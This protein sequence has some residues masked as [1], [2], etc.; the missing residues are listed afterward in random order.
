[1]MPYEYREVK[2][3]WCDQIF[4]WNKTGGEGLLVYE[5]RLKST[6]EYVARAKCPSCEMDMIVL[7][8]ILA[9]IAVDDD[10]LERIGV[11]G[12]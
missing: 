9:G 4:M 12:I 11:R 6:G 2:C 1:M 3:P 10:R 5:Y 8:H 7:D